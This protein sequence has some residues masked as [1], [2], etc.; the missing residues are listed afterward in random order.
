[1]RFRAPL[2]VFE[3]ALSGKTGGPDKNDWLMSIPAAASVFLVGTCEF[4]CLAA[5]YKGGP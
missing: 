1:V 4:W 2:R 5:A 3:R